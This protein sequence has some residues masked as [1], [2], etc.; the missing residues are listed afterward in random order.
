[1]ESLAPLSSG[2]GLWRDLGLRV[3]GEGV[4]LGV[5]QVSLEDAQRLLP[6]L[7]GLLATADQITRRGVVTGLGQRDP[8]QRRVELPVPGPRQPMPWDVAGPDRQRGGAVVTGVGVGAVGAGDAGGLTED[9]RR[10]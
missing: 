2:S 4:V 5:G 7:A 9:L 3:G 10:G 8:M 6:A 1:V